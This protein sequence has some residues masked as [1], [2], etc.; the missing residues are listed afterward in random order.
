MTVADTAHFIAAADKANITPATRL[1]L[2]VSV[3]VR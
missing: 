2:V 3:E 1:S